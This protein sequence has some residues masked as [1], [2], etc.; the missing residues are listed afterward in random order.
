MVAYP[1]IW[2][3][4]WSTDEFAFN[5]LIQSLI[6]NQMLGGHGIKRTGLWSYDLVTT[7][8]ADFFWMKEGNYFILIDI[9][10]V[11][12]KLSFSR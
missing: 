3:Q 2:Y 11:G 4:R 9:D 7:N 1:W 5:V 8:F 12:R 10:K 6:S